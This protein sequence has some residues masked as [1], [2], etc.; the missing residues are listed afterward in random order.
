MGL[1]EAVEV[2]AGR[3]PLFAVAGATFLGAGAV[4]HLYKWSILNSIPMLGEELG[5]SEKRR[6]AYTTGAKKMYQ[7]GYDKVWPIKLPVP[8]HEDFL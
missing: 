3:W 2:L 1:D 6:A 4:G 8:T 7:D 5:G